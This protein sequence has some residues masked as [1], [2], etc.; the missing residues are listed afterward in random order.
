MCLVNCIRENCPLQMYKNCSNITICVEQEPKKNGTLTSLVECTDVHKTPFFMVLDQKSLRYIYLGA[1][2][3]Q[4]D[5][6]KWLAY[7]GWSVV[8][9]AGNNKDTY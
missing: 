9:N 3:K 1:D 6:V 7:S 4:L 2:E 5:D 8:F